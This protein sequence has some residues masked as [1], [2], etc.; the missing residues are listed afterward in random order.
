M[1]MLRKSDLIKMLQSIEGDP[2]VIIQKDAEGDNFSPLSTIEGGFYYYPETT[3][4][5]YVVEDEDMDEEDYLD[6]DAHKCI[7]VY[8]IN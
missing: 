5:G 2:V 3:W 7:L 6:E 1:P 8:P 4:S